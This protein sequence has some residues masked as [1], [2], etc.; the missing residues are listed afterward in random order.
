MQKRIFIWFVLIVVIPSGIIYFL[1]NNFFLNYAVNKQIATNTQLIDEMRKNLDTQLLH[2]Q[3]LTMELY[4]NAEA[5]EEITA[6]TDILDC[7]AVQSQLDSFVNA[8]RLISS[9]YLFTEKGSLYSGH[10]LREIDQ[11]VESYQEKLIEQDGRILW[12]TSYPL[13]TNFGLNDSYFFGM[14]H[15]RQDEKPIATLCLGFSGMFFSDFFQYTPFEN[16]HGISIYQSEG[17]LIASNGVDAEPLL[18]KEMLENSYHAARAYSS[19]GADGEDV[20]ILSSRSRLS[21]WI[22]IL[23]LSPRQI[24]DELSV[25]QRIFYISL[26]CYFL[27]FFYLSYMVSKKLG[28]PLKD[29]TDA[30]NQVG[31]GNL[32]ITVE[33]NHIDEIRQLSMGFNSMTHRV[34]QLLDEIRRTEKE[35]RRA[36]LQNLQLQLTP[37]FLYNTLN[38][39]RWMAQINGQ[40]NIMSVTKALIGYLKS[41]TDIE[42]EFIPLEKEIALIEA[43]ATIQLYRYREFSITYEI[44][45]YLK[46]EK[47]HKLMILNIVENSII[48]GF[49]EQEGAGQITISVRKDADDL[50]ITI[51][52]N[53]VGFP[54]DTLLEIQELLDQNRS[55]DSEPSDAQ[56]GHIG[57]RNIQYRLRLYHGEQYALHIA[58]HEGD[59]CTVWFRQ[60]LMRQPGFQYLPSSGNNE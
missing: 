50:V 42:S 19:S 33:E 53:G 37:H 60:P 2:Y 28:K 48:H 41:L 14:R 45:E 44:P 40:E 24:S 18:D 15:I 58:S 52:D 23:S 13:K 8:N 6:E 29:L 10:G 35:K 3:Q 36:Y 57:L 30:I 7:T 11:I 54:P 49:S 4:L 21:D 47:I 34:Q 38:T 22:I 39:I 46:K 20:L 1:A 27:F 5:M 31:D 25:I 43:Y 32:D 12:T 55:I 16:S 26:V 9:A 59:G 17:K 51:N 56:E